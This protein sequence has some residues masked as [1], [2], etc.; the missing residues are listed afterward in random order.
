MQQ[1]INAL[2]PQLE[3]LHLLGSPGLQWG[4]R[5]YLSNWVFHLTFPNLHSFTL[6]DS[7]RH[8]EDAAARLAIHKFWECHPKLSWVI[9]NW[10]SG[11][12]VPRVSAL[13]ESQRL[14]TVSPILPNLRYL[15]VSQ[16]YRVIFRRYSWFPGSNRRYHAHAL[17]VGSPCLAKRGKLGLGLYATPGRPSRPWVFSVIGAIA[18]Q[19]GQL[20]S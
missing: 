14:A 16:S 15:G 12:T 8:N 10:T 11:T 1:L 13:E 3:E 17:E 5:P 7:K 20:S 2:S 9:L 18:S 4:G 6:N 19:Q